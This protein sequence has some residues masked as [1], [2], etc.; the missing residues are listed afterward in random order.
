M[1]LESEDY[2]TFWTRYGTYKYKVLP[3]SLTNGP[4]TFQRFINDIL[5]EYFDDF[6]AAYIDDILIY[7]STPEE[8]EVH[9]KKVMAILQAH[10]LQA[11][12]K[13]SEFSV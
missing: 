13:K 12:I 4:A 9:V 2:T 8:H 1:S 3:F 10:G 6:C 5:I 7:S 11:D